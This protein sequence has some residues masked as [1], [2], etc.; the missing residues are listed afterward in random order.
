MTRLAIGVGAALVS[1]ACAAPLLHRDLEQ[2]SGKLRQLVVRDLGKPYDAPNRT[3][4][5]VVVELDTEPDKTFGFALRGRQAAARHGMLELLRDA[6]GAGRPVAIAYSLA[7]DNVTRV[8][9]RV[10]LAGDP[11][12]IVQVTD[13]PQLVPAA[14]DP[15]IQ[16]GRLD[17]SA[18]LGQLPNPPPGFENKGAHE[19]FE[20]TTRTI[21]EEK[22]LAPGQ[23]RQATVSF[24]EPVLLQARATWFGSIEPVELIVAMGGATLA[25][26]TVRP[27]P[28][29]RGTATADVRVHMPGTATVSAFNKGSATVHLEIV[30]G[31]LP[32]SA[33]PARIR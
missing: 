10:S 16:G 11:A 28:P 19:F 18:I 4:L 13:V 15:I 25:R 24:T 7:P 23:T 21:V 33:T 29:N 32:L 3:D 2:T 9:H 5:Q 8:I 20:E 22:G 12:T 30:V 31:T 26:G 14:D 6:L 17:P 1:T 27:A